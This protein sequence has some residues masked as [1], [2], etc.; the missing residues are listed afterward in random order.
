[1]RKLKADKKKKSIVEIIYIAVVGFFNTP[2][3]Y[4]LPLADSFNFD[5][6]FS[7]LLDIISDNI[8]ISFL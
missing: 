3:L 2:N 1:M 5:L 4:L 8:P 7:I 6:S